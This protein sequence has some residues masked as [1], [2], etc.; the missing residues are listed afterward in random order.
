MDAGVL[1]LPGFD[2]E[3]LA[4]G[5]QQDDSNVGAHGSTTYYYRARGRRSA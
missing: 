2:N 3:C 4:M 5:A 1:I